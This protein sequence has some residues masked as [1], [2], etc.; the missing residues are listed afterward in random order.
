MKDL[1]SKPGEE[2]FYML[3]VAVI[4]QQ[5]DILNQ[6]GGGVE[7]LYIWRRFI[8]RKQKVRGNKVR[9]NIV[10]KLND[11]FEVIK[12]YDVKT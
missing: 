3:W 1:G 9:G 8:M 11:A 2:V 6:R 4:S 12:K 5:A 7:A 10:S